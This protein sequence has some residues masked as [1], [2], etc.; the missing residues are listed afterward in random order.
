MEPRIAD[1]EKYDVEQEDMNLHPEDGQPPPRGRCIIRAL[2]WFIFVKDGQFIA[3]IHADC[4]DQ[5]W[6]GVEVYGFAASLSGT[7]RWHIMGGFWS[8]QW[9]DK[10]VITAKIDPALWLETKAG[11]TYV[12][13]DPAP[14]YSDIWKVVCHSW[15]PVAD[16]ADPTYR[17]VD[18]A[19]PRPIWWGGSRAWDYVQR[20]V[21]EEKKKAEGSNDE[22]EVS[23]RV[24]RKTPQRKDAQRKSAKRKSGSRVASGRKSDTPKAS[25]GALDASKTSIPTRVEGPSIPRCSDNAMGG[26]TRGQSSSQHQMVSPG[27]PSCSWY[28]PSWTASKGASSPDGFS[29]QTTG[30]RKNPRYA[31]INGDDIF[32]PSFGDCT[33]I[34]NVSPN[35]YGPIMDY[36]ASFGG[37]GQSA[38]SMHPQALVYGDI[39]GA[40]S[41]PQVWGDQEAFGPDFNHPPDPPMIAYPGQIIQGQTVP[42]LDSRSSSRH[43]LMFVFED[44]PTD[45]YGFDKMT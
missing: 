37:I 22:L 45:T 21:E 29:D 27:S 12:L 28:T 38:A 33:T 32:N 11:K 5:F 24:K 25:V 3:P 13:L 16:G 36:A 10:Q 35:L 20:M 43:D 41:T 34:S 18:P 30:P 15:T 1:Y 31:E 19:F 7:A 14:E 42:G 4:A 17:D 23:K 26:T 2:N 8:Y 40:E 44:L 6:K 39:E 9:G